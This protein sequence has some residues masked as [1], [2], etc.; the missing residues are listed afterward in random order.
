MGFHLLTRPIPVPVGAGTGTGCRNRKNPQGR[1]RGRKH[2]ITC[3]VPFWATIPRAIQ[4]P[5]T[6]QSNES[7]SM[8]SDPYETVEGTYTDGMGATNTAITTAR[9]VQSQFK[10]HGRDLHTLFQGPVCTFVFRLSSCQCP[11]GAPKDSVA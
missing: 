3:S 5:K 1:P 10:N 6:S 9:H 2:P 4:I 8:S 11:T 7:F